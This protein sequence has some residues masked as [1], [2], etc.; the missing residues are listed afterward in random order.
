MCVCVLPAEDWPA[1]LQVLVA[2]VDVLPT[3]LTDLHPVVTMHRTQAAP[4][5]CRTEGGARQG[6][7]HLGGE[8]GAADALCASQCMPGNH[9]PYATP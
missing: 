5:M 7:Q 4:S 1:L 2:T 6:R 3:A 8:G 9:Q